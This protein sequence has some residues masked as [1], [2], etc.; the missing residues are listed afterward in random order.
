MIDRR[1]FL[2]SSLALA[3]CDRNAAAQSAPRVVPPLKSLAAFPVGTCAMTGQFDDPQWV[4]L[5]TRHFSQLTPEW[6]MKM[7][8]ILGGDGRRRWDAPDRIAA[9]ARDHGLGLHATTLIWYAQD[10][11][12]FKSL[13]GE[14]FAREY[15]RWIADVAGRYAGQAS[16]WD[17]VNEPVAEDG[18]GLRDC[19]YSRA[20]GQDGYMIRAFEQARLADP[21]A[22]LF[23]NDYNLENNP[24]K[25]ATF[26]RLVERLLKAGAPIGGIG[27]QSHLDIEIP[28]GQTAAF[29][30]EAAQFGLPIHVSE[31]DASLRREGALIDPPQGVP[32]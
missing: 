15:D 23:L 24:V 17:V 21:S 18:K 25:G 11:P 14:R 13:T 5:T 20:L 6:E 28:A 31:L 3:A 7:E 27:T 9:F 8:Y 1:A 2:A 19:L 29:M 4:E 32:P 10:H 16:G 12:W 30:R 26:L 22:V